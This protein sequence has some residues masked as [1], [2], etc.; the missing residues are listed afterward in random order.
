MKFIHRLLKQDAGAGIVEYGLIVALI[1]IVSL[2]SVKALG[3]STS[4][5]LTTTAQSIKHSD[6]TDDATTTT[7]AGPGTESTTTTVAAGSGG[8]GGSGGSEDSEGTGGGGSGGSG[9]SEATT[10][11][12]TAPATTTTTIPEAT[13]TTLAPPTTKPPVVEPDYPTAEAGVKGKVMVTFAYVDGK[14]VVTGIDAGPEWSMKI[15][16]ESGGEIILEF[17]DPKTGEVITVRGWVNGGGKLKTKVT[18]TTP[19]KGK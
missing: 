4:G 15:V 11:T 13:T 3:Y 6:N 5:S 19:K 8:S 7:T 17:T 1:A 12:T 14:L 10:T 18:V 2:T 16:K 9:G